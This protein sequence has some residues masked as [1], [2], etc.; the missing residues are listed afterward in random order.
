[1]Y[2]KVS[3]A[4]MEREPEPLPQQVEEI[5]VEIREDSPQSSPPDSPKVTTPR[6]SEPAEEDYR[7]EAEVM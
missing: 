2:A 1:M 6:L 5:N 7:I 3:K 4:P